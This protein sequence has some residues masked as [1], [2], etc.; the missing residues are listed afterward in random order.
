MLLGKKM[1]IKKKN[2]IIWPKV[3]KQLFLQKIFLAF[4]GICH[5][6]DLCNGKLKTLSSINELKLPF[7]D[8]SVGSRVI[9]GGGNVGKEVRAKVN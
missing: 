4:Y 9:K 6:F 7:F 2:I 5:E 1:Q 8:R 3:Y